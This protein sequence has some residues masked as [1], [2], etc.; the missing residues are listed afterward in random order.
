MNSSTD[1]TPTESPATPFVHPS[2]LAARY[3]VPAYAVLALA[4]RG[5]IPASKVGSTYVFKVDEV[6]EAIARPKAFRSASW[7]A[8]RYSVTPRTITGLAES[9]EIPSI[10]VGGQWRFDPDAVHAALTSHT[11]QPFT[12][13]VRRPRSQPS[14]PPSVVATSNACP[15]VASK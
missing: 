2:A 5:E 4:K 14:S 8:D 7:I 9:G 13:R 6:D 10:K 11:T 15:T 3:G 1:T 12:T